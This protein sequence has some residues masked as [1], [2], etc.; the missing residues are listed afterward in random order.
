MNGQRG[1]S[2]GGP[3]TTSSSTDNAPGSR[4]DLDP[5]LVAAGATVLSLAA[6]LIYYRAGDILLYGDAVAHMNI[7]RRVFDSRTPGLLQL[8]TVWLPLPHLLTLPFVSNHWLWQTGIGGSIPSLIAYTFAVTG[9]GRLTRALLASIGAAQRRTRLTVVAS[10]AICALNPNL[11]YLQSTA[12]TEPLYLALFIWSTVYMQEFISVTHGNPSSATPAA[13]RTVLKSLLCAAAASLTRYD[14]WFLSATLAGILIVLYLRERLDIEAH[15]YTGKLPLRGPKPAIALAR[16]LLILAIAPA[17]WLAYNAI[18]YRNPLEF[19]NGPYSAKAIERKSVPTAPSHPGMNDV[20]LAAIYFVKCAEINVANGRLAFLW[21][22]LAFGATTA[23]AFRHRLATSALLWSPIAFY[24]LSI[25]YGGV[26][27]YMPDWYPYSAYNV[28]YGLQLLPAFAVLA[29]VAVLMIAER[30]RNVTSRRV[31]ALTITVL[32]VWSYASLWHAQPV[33]YREAFINS[34][35]RLAFESQLASQLS[36][37]PA[38]SSFLM[39]LG[40]HVGALQQ[41]GI[42]LRRSVNEG[43]HRVW[44]QPSDPNGIWERSLAHP[45]EFV[46]YVVAMDGDPVADAMR[47]QSLSAVDRIQVE[48]QPVATIY[49]AR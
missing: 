2:A 25:A 39:Y 21:L 8:G 27:L 19:A 7:A 26:P 13:N 14:G 36:R 33:C 41:A 23:L 20:A 5:L 44:V 38:G 42:P 47:A 1:A 11:L 31:T 4:R 9:I 18:V 40:N 29:P 43:N 17:L 35:T 49:R 15:L 48:G 12:M 30:L 28:R 24:A 6:F 10:A 34:R 46:D 22:L 32:F 45:P 3:R 16:S 37:L